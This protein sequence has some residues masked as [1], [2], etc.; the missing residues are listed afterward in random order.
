MYLSS[1]T[2]ACL[3]LSNCLWAAVARDDNGTQYQ[4]CVKRPLLKADTV[5]P[6]KLANL[7]EHLMLNIT[8]TNGTQHAFGFKPQHRSFAPK[9]E[10]RHHRDPRFD[11]L[12]SFNLNNTALFSR[13]QVM[14]RSGLPLVHDRQSHRHQ[15]RRKDERLHRNGRG[16][17]P[18]DHSQP[19][20]P[21]E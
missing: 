16:A 19:L 1:F 9:P 20:H 5:H 2:V 8:T 12:A 4:R 21:V 7:T 13:T 6:A 3:T 11:Q 14:N 15:R 10:V 17:Q 18:H